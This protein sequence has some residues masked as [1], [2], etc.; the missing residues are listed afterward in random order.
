MAKKI[1][2]IV[3]HTK[4]GPGA[5]LAGSTNTYE[6]HWNSDLANK[7]R[8]AASSITGVECKIFTRDQGGLAGAYGGAIEWGATRSVWTKWNW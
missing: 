1:A 2:I 4:R 5:K 6:Y 8:Q 3:G 7:M